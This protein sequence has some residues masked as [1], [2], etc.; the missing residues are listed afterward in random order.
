[1]SG[2]L[3]WHHS[4]MCMRECAD[5]YSRG[6]LFLNDPVFSQPPVCAAAVTIVI[7]MIAPQQKGHVCY[8][9]LLNIRLPERHRSRQSAWLAGRRLTGFLSD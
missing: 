4:C 8:P 9:T 7:L 2:P 3:V 5:F 6:P 1:M